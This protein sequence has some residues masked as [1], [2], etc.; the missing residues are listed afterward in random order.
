MGAGAEAGWVAVRDVDVVI[1]VTAATDPSEWII[2]SRPK[3]SSKLSPTWENWPVCPPKD[4]RGT[5]EFWPEESTGGTEEDLDVGTKDCKIKVTD[6]DLGCFLG[7]S[8]PLSR[9]LDLGTLC[10]VGEDIFTTQSAQETTRKE[11]FK[12]ISKTSAH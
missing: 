1:R 12:K 7:L 11:N 3:V 8:D 5:W 6:E 9:D 10:S 4:G 2:K